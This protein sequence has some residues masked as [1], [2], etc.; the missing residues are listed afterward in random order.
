MSNKVKTKSSSNKRLFTPDD[1]NMV[2]LNLFR[3]YDNN[4]DGKFSRK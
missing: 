3:L 4:G 2:L 1:I